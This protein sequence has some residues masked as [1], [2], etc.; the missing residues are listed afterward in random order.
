[1]IV[2]KPTRSEY[3]TDGVDRSNVKFTLTDGS[4]YVGVTFFNEF[5]ESL[6]KALE[7]KLKDPVII[8]IAS[9]KIGKWNGNNLQCTNL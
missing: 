5:G 4:S 3:K 2:G 1:M 7:Q 8:I 6:L 9:A